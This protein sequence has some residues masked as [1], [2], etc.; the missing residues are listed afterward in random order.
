MTAVRRLPLKPPPD[1]LGRWHDCFAANPCCHL[2]SQS[3][4]AL[5]VSDRPTQPQ[6]PS[7]NTN[8]EFHLEWPYLQPP[9][10]PIATSKLQ[11][12]DVGYTQQHMLH[13]QLQLHMCT[14]VHMC[15]HGQHVQACGCGHAVV[16]HQ[17]TMQGRQHTKPLPARFSTFGSICTGRPCQCRWR[18]VPAALLC[19]QALQLH[20][21]LPEPA[22]VHMQHAASHTHH[23]LYLGAQPMPPLL[24]SS[25]LHPAHHD[26]H[27]PSSL[28]ATSPGT[29]NRRTPLSP[30]T[31]CA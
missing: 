24:C 14:R 10:G 21:R 2:R 15:L 6:G 8:K 28:G 25:S 19:Q 30:G 17:R 29:S 23:I 4:F 13:L 7:W 31:R 1:R 18:S 11:V 16:S 22:C 5:L 12:A 3:S 27:D 26:D 20:A 9:M